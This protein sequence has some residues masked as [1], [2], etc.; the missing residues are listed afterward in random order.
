MNTDTASH[1]RNTDS[2]R[3]ARR[4]ML[5][6]LLTALED[7]GND[8]SGVYSQ[9]RPLPTHIAVISKDPNRFTNE[10]HL[11][12]LATLYTHQLTTK[13]MENM[14]S[15][16]MDTGTDGQPL[17]VI[18]INTDHLAFLET[19]YQD[20]DSQGASTIPDRLY[21]KIVNRI[22]DNMFDSWNQTTCKTYA[23][24][25]TEQAARCAFKSVYDMIREVPGLSKFENQRLSDEWAST[26]S[27]TLE[28]IEPIENAC[29]FHNPE[30]RIDAGMVIYP[31]NAAF[32]SEGQSGI[33][34]LSLD[35]KITPEYLKGR[36]EARRQ[37]TEVERAGALRR[38]ATGKYS[39][40]DLAQ[41]TKLT[42][43][44]RSRQA[45]R[46]TSY[47]ELQSQAIERT[48]SRNEGV[49]SEEYYT[50]ADLATAIRFPTDE[51][52]P[53]PVGHVRPKG[54]EIPF[55]SEIRINFW[56]TDKR[57]SATDSF[58]YFQEDINSLN[59]SLEAEISA[60]VKTRH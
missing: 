39:Q 54:P 2:V 24:F 44:L 26:W 58:K 20:T 59:E 40:H 34:T 19:K 27:K 17:P 38:K 30:K 49:S 47:A 48:L 57:Q 14:V 37:M 3:D 11:E 31:E 33:E 4:K 36:I 18:N 35:Q 9:W 23:P 56:H 55:D 53:L 15:C 41:P 21:R 1:Q 10:D 25:R 46:L 5:R 45:E 52:I 22:K 42:D 16:T 50:Q 29:Y 8:Y 28:A 32:P 43:E 12:G 7:A 13:K 51:S 6:E 60:A